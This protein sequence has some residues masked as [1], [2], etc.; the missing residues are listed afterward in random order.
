MTE[1]LLY[2]LGR[3]IIPKGMRPNLRIWLLKAGYQDVP[4]SLFGLTFLGSLLLAG[5]L[6]NFVAVYYIDLSQFEGFA[7]FLPAFFLYAVFGFFLLFTAGVIIYFFWNL[8]IFKRTKELESLLPD[9][10]TLVSTNLKGGMSF[11]N[12]LWGAIKPEFGILAN[13]IGL[14]SKRVMTGN[15]VTEALIEFSMKY[16]SPIL[17]RNMQLL[18]SEVESGGK[19]VQT[20]DKIIIDMKK[21]EAL[22]KEMA[23]STVTYMIFIGML[24]IL[25]APVLFALSL[26][27]FS[28]ITSFIGSL[29]G[30]IGPNNAGLTIGAP[31]V[32][33]EDFRMF[34]IIAIGI[35]STFSSMIIAIIEKGDLRAGLKY[36]PMFLISSLTIYFIASGLLG[37]IFGGLRF[38]S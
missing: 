19:I 26:Q 38:G 30:N 37:A 9:Y 29:A 23:S 32:S 8:K 31:Q 15:D 6:F 20:I 18:I 35:I 17:R 10:L 1:N 28:I 13:E 3:S 11:E 14:V 33:S 24:V 16:E 2:T 27:L 4:Y 34:S 12:A 21:T 36:I 25:I 7:Y 5:L 22:K